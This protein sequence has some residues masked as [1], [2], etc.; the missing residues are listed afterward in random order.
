MTKYLHGNRIKSVADVIDLAKHVKALVLC[1]IYTR[2]I[3]TTRQ[4]DVADLASWRLYGTCGSSALQFISTE[5]NSRS[6]LPIILEEHS[7]DFGWVIADCELKDRFEELYNDWQIGTLFIS[8]STE[9]TLHKSL[10]R[11]IGLGYRVVP[12]LLEKL[13][14]EPVHVFNA[15]AAIT[16]EEP[17]PKEY[18]GNVEKMREY[19]LEWGM[20]RGLIATSR[21]SNS[22]V[23]PQACDFWISAQQP[24]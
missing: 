12:F 19:W 6:T 8:S 9:I 20:F 2:N 5:L 22:N 23:V 7:P 24:V 17:V 16:W 10:Q 18:I 4:F 3:D 21:D 1:S 11:I 14:A 15:L 13:R